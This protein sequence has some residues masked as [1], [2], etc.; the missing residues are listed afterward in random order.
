MVERN[1]LDALDDC[2][3]RLGDGQTIDDC[4]RAHPQYAARLRPMLEAG[5]LVKRAQA[6]RLEIAAAQDRVRFRVAQAT[7]E[8]PSQRHQ[9]FRRLTQLIAGLVLVLMIGLG[10]GIFAQSSLPGDLL[11]GFKLTSE[12]I[13]LSL[14]SN[15]RTI[16]ERFAQR[17]IE[18]TVRLLELMRT[19]NVTFEGR[20]QSMQGNLWHV[21]SLSVLVETDTPISGDVHTG[22]QIRVEGFTTPQGELFA[23][24]ITLIEQG[25]SEFPPVPTTTSV[26]TIA[27]SFTSTPA[28]S[29]TPAPSAT[30]TNTPVTQTPTTA[31]TVT[32]TL[33]PTPSP[34]IRISPTATICSP[35]MPSGWVSYAIQTG[36]TLSDLAARTD[37]SIDQLLTVNCLSDPRLIIVGQQIFLPRTPITVS[38]PTPPSS[39]SNDNGSTNPPPSNNNDNADNN[40]DNGGS[41]NSNGNDNNNSNNSNSN[42]NSGDDHGGHGGGSGGNGSDD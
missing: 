32:A 9:P 12:S 3:D 38:S 33:T 21:E 41:G 17:R 34:T 5:T 28:P 19:E 6:D 11:Y 39:G 13:I 1:L 7:A 10:T 30:P 2:I 29:V 26:P 37:I 16:T 40:E 27:P 8:M 4:L 36:D 18:E 14:S 23:S 22:D 35:I 20:L 31:P 15:D 24:R 42:D 25:S